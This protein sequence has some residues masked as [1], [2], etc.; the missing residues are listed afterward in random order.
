MRLTATNLFNNYT[1]SVV[2]KKVKKVYLIIGPSC[3]WYDP[4]VTGLLACVES[5]SLGG[6]V[7]TPQCNNNKDFSRIPAN[8]YICQ[9]SGQ[10]HAWDF[11]PTVSPTLPWPDCTGELSD[12]V[13]LF[14]LTIIVQPHV[15]L[16]YSRV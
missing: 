12:D 1:T 13:L 5:V 6:T 8:L 2:V 14:P 15:Y 9:T 11:R 16:Y 7:C 10:W 4:P 3:S